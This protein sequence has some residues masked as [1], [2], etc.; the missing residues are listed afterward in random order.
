M[1]NYKQEREN[2]K[3][4]LSARSSFAPIYHSGLVQGFTHREG[5]R[6]RER[7]EGILTAEG[8]CSESSNATLFWILALHN[9]SF[10]RPSQTS[11]KLFLLSFSSS[12][13][14]SFFFLSIFLFIHTK[15]HTRRDIFLGLLENFFPFS[16]N[17]NN[18]GEDILY[19]WFFTLFLEE[20]ILGIITFFFFFFV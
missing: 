10:L 16:R 4:A 11:E 6:E 20:E 8:N 7:A 1:N 5:E 19:T 2:R 9:A 15:E 13:S 17:C 3:H 14:F 12:S 18:R